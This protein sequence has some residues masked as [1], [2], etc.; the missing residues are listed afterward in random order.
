[1]LD[2]GGLRK[3]QN[4]FQGLLVVTSGSGLCAWWVLVSLLQQ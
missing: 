1:M 4:A 3:R 2:V